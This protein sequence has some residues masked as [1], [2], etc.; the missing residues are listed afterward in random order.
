MKRT[1]QQL[2]GLVIS[3]LWGVTFIGGTNYLNANPDSDLRG[4]IAAISCVMLVLFGFGVFRTLRAADEMEQ[5]VQEKAMS[6]PFGCSVIGTI[7]Y[8]ILDQIGR[9]SLPDPNLFFVGIGMVL[10]YTGAN[11]V[12]RRRMGLSMTTC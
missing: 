1:K 9:I 3:I 7:F 6:I 5:K 8:A 2:E 12:I 4:A 11:V 10:V